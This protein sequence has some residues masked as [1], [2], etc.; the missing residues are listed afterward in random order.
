MKK[1]F[2]LFVMLCAAQIGF[3]QLKVDAAGNTL[4]SGNIYIGG[5]SNFLAT[6]SNVP[7][8]FKVN[9]SESAGSTGSL[10]K[11][12]VSFGYGSL[13]D[14]TGNYNTAHGYYALRANTTGYANTAN[15]YT[16]LRANTTGYEN[17]ALGSFALLYN[18]TGSYNTAI[19]IRALRTNTIGSY[20]TAIG[21]NVDV[22]A[23]NLNNATAIGNGAIATASNQV[24]IGN[25]NVTSIGGYAA[26]TNISDGRAKK[27]IRA[28][29]PGLNFINSLQPVTYNL[30]LDAIDELLKSDDPKINRLKDS[31]RTARSSQKNW[32][33]NQEL[34]NK[35]RC[36]P[37]LWR[38]M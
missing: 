15:G 29:V 7:I 12:N 5:S 32:K 2:F 25:N 6:T 1:N 31:L 21:H 8:V 35:N 26:W 24:R 13:S 9:N 14:L 3:A 22:S 17:S 37:V 38:R 28:D 19:G 27:N 11:Y 23:N 36:K 10:S 18:T 16:T 4:V 20:N 30:D 33:Q 34:Q